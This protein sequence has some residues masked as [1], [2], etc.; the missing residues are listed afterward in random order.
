MR[1]LIFCYLAFLA[2]IDVVWA[3]VFSNFA[4]QA[5]L[6][7]GTARGV[8]ANQSHNLA[9]AGGS[10][11]FLVGLFQSIIFDVFLTL[12]VVVALIIWGALRTKREG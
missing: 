3:Y 11:V 5:L 6:L 4:S 7:V 2:L 8:D 1:K 12:V 10:A 9:H